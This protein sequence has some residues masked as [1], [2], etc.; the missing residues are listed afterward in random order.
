M[1]PTDAGDTGDKK[2][3]EPQG[4]FSLKPAGRKKSVN[5]K[6]VGVI[7]GAI[8]MMLIITV[9]FSCAVINNRGS[10]NETEVDEGKVKAEPI[11]RGYGR[12]H[13]EI[14]AFMAA[15]PQKVDEA[16]EGVTHQPPPPPLPNV[17]E[18]ASANAVP[19]A[20]PVEREPEVLFSSI[21]RF[22]SSGVSNG[23]SGGGSEGEISSGEE[24]RLREFA[25]ADPMDK[26]RELLNSPDVNSGNKGMLGQLEATR[27]YASAKAHRSPPAKF[28]LKRRTNFQCVLYTAIKTDYP[29]FVGCRLTRP[30]YSADGSVILAEAGAE[31][32]GEQN[33]EI[34]AGQ[35]S[36]FTSWTEL[37]TA[38]GVRASLNGLGTDPM[39]RSGTDAHIDNHYGDR[40]GGAVMLSFVKDALAT[41]SNR[42]KKSN[43]SGYNVDNT[44]QNA[45]DMAG[46][47]LENSITI[48]PT[49]YVLPG[50][51]INV[52][53][54]QDIDFSSVYTTRR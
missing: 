23:A 48:P 35:S 40:F 36:V 9:V 27:E 16:T 2:T 29:G 52:I 22:E 38:P 30:L 18:A 50:T 31:L 45:E 37:E 12:Q 11:T 5:W 4:S 24:R 20:V 53:V 19:V 51:V 44:E 54:A 34:K 46:K 7:G 15:H 13:D 21:S 32:T 8:L 33:V 6:I 41:V 25:N 1:R 42:A 26:V 39:G 17:D 28:L 3:F 14:S 43:G 10:G 49:G 47:A